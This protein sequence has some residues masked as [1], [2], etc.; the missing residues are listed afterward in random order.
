MI[1]IIERSENMFYMIIYNMDNFND[2]PSLSFET[3]FFKSLI[4][5]LYCIAI[6]K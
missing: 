3:D 5:N 6:G 1:Y 2:L 4:S